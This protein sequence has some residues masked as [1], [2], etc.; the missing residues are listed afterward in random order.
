MLVKWGCDLADRN[1]V[2]VYVDAS[3]AG[4]LLYQKFGFID[5]RLGSETESDIVPMARA[6]S[7]RV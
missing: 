6:L 4:M 2:E 1:G 7:V 3:Q 5:K